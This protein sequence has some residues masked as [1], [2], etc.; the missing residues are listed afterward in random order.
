MNKINLSAVSNSEALITSSHFLILSLSECTKLCLIA[1]WATAA[2]GTD[3]VARE[4]ARL[5]RHDAESICNNTPA[6][7]FSRHC[8]Q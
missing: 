8:R 4:L 3:R 6:G 5:P 7:V 2:Q 1:E